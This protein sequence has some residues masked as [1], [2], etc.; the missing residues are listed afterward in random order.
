MLPREEGRAVRAPQQSHLVV[1]CHHVLER[2]A[3]ASTLVLHRSRD[4]FYQKDS[5]KANC[6]TLGSPESVVML[7]AAPL[8]MFPLGWPNSGVLVRLKTSHRNCRC[9]RSVMW[10]SRVSATSKT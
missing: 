6:I 2:G 4:F 9:A 7:P 8:V 5:L 3:R 1:T 10:K